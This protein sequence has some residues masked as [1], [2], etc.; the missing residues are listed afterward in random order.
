MGWFGC[1]L[2]FTLGTRPA[3]PSSVGAVEADQDDP[4]AG[5]AASG[6]DDL[7]RHQT[8]FTPTSAVGP[9]T[10]SSPRSASNLASCMARA[11]LG[12]PGSRRDRRGCRQH[13]KLLRERHR[14]LRRDTPQAPPRPSRQAPA[15][16]SSMKTKKA[17]AVRAQEIREATWSPIVLDRPYAIKNLLP[18]T[19]C[20]LRRKK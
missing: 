6:L 16:S 10:S 5:V 17:E 18:P 4:G 12:C 19:A 14:R 20:W 7:E 8:V 13:R 11:A 2:A 15:R 9:S 1:D 3:S